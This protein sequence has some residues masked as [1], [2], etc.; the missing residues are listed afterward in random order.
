MRLLKLFVKQMKVVIGKY[1]GHIQAIKVKTILA[2]PNLNNKE[3]LDIYV[4]V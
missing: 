3:T 2:F 1:S 4:K